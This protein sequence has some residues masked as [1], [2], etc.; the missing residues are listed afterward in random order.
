MALKEIA[1]EMRAML[2]HIMRCRN[3]VIIIKCQDADCPHCSHHPIV[4]KKL[5]QFLRERDMKMFAP[6]PSTDNEGHYCTFLKMCSKH[7]DELSIVDNGMPS[8][9]DSDLGNCPCPGLILSN[10]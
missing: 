5:F 7:K 8:A 4:A 2:K 9:A 3:E 10:N 1:L 6:Q